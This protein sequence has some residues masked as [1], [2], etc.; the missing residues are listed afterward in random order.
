MITAL[1][2]RLLITALALLAGAALA[3]NVETPGD[4]VPLGRLYL[5]IS[6]DGRDDLEA[7][8]ATLEAAEAAGETQPDPVVVILHGQEALPFVRRNY[9]DNQVIV[10]RAARLKAFGRVELRMCETWMRTNGLDQSDLLPF[11]D[12]VPLAP[13]EVQRLG[14]EGYVP[15][16][17]VT[18]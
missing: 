3:Q 10:D 2:P 9:L 1:L 8:F 6:P 5:E 13:E 12:T 7:L 16:S 11:V 4:E 15:Y 18:L 14:R 17:K